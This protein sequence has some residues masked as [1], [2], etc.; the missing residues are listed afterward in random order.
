MLRTLLIAFI[1]ILITSPVF[2]DT[3]IYSYTEED[4]T[5]HFTNVPTDPAFRM[6]IPPKREPATRD[7]KISMEE[8][9]RLIVKKS[10]HYGLDPA[11]VR[12]IVAVESN[13][14]P[15][16]LSSKGA[17]GLMQLMPET[18]TALGVKN[19]FDPEEN[20]DGGIR[21]LR[22]LIDIFNRD[23]DLAL[24]AYHAGVSRVKKYLSI[25]PIPATQEYVRKVK[26]IY[27][28]GHF[29]GDD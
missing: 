3:G 11:L 25:P 6:I 17:A 27:E 14:N 1:Y 19:V 18:A 16:A 28:S 26:G 15:R 20:I 29:G 7:G 13:F 21:Y 23:L 24:A 8:I 9:S 22:Y 5:V 10:Y 12:A 4:G 2:A